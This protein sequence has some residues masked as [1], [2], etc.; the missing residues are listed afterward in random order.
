MYFQDFMIGSSGGIDFAEN[1][2][3]PIP[4]LPG[5]KIIALHKSQIS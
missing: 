1:L 4:D 2:T 3:P 5:Q